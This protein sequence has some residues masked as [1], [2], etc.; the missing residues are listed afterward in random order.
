[1]ECLVDC[2]SDTFVM[3]VVSQTRMKCEEA[4]PYVISLCHM[5]LS[6]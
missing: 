2:P 5:Q 6:V 1:M 3:E 4:L